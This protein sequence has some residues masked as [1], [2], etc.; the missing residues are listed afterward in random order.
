MHLMDFWRPLAF[1]H[2]HIWPE[3][4]VV[5]S[6]SGITT[7]RRKLQLMLSDTCSTL[8]LSSVGGGEWQCSC[9]SC[10]F[11]PYMCAVLNRIKS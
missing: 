3:Y 1:D 6:Y 11:R 9:V 4:A 2:V 10:A 8:M 5:F 7:C